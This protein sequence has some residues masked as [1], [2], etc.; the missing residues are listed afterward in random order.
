MQLNLKLFDDFCRFASAQVSSG[1]IDPV[2]P[3]L[4]AHYDK[5]GLDAEVAIWR[6]FLYVT[7]YS[8]GSAEIVW[9][10]LPVPAHAP[11]ETAFILPTGIERRGFRGNML[12]VK[13]INEFY[14][15]TRRAGGIMAWLKSAIGKGGEAGWSRVRAQLK[16]IPQAGDWAS[17]KWADLLKHVHGFPIT[18]SDIGVGGNGKNAGPVPGMVQLT[19]MDWRKAANDVSAQRQL[20]WEANVNDANLNG[21]D[22]LETALCDF[23]SLTHGRYYVGHDIDDM[24]AKLAPDSVFWEGRRIGLDNAYLGELH[25]WTGVDKL[26][27]QVYMLNGEVWTRS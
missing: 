6:T 5:L 3:V 4:K 7:Y 21:L 26:R 15:I 18:A 14:E 16:E 8:L 12:P 19:G 27:K 1:D 25:G 17:Y 11:Q 22:Q 13:H 23:N 10:L 2:Y 9:K 24:Q 20:L